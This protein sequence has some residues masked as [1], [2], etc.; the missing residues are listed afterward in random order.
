MEERIKLIGQPVSLMEAT[1]KVSGRYKY[2]DDM[3]AELYVKILRSPHPHSRIESIDT[4]RAEELEG[5]EAVLTHKDVPKRLMPRG[6][7]RACYVLEDHVRFVGDEVAAVAAKSKAVAEEALELIK[8]E[9]KVLPAVFDP[10]EAVKEDA[11]RIYPEGNVCGPQLEPLVEKGINTPAVYEWGDVEKGFREADV[12]IEDKFEVRPQVHTPIETHVCIASWEGGELTILIATQ[13]PY[14]VRDS[15]AYVLEMPE[16]RVRVLSPAIGGGFGSKEVE[17]YV[18]ITALLSSKAGGKSTKIVFTREEE[19]CHAKRGECK[20]HVKVGARKDGTITAILFKAYF[21]L[22]GYG[23]PTGGSCNFW[24]ESPALSYKAE[25]ARFEGWDVHTNHFTSQ[26]YRSVQLVD[27]VFA[28]EQAIDE[29]AEE[30]GM[31]PAEFRLKNMP[32]SGDTMPPKPH[33]TTLAP[34]PQR[35]KLDVYPSKKLMRNVM[36]KA[37]FGRWRGWGKPIAT[38]GPKR[39]GI[40]M[41]YA[42]GYSGFVWDGFMSMSLVLNKDGSANILS[43][44]QDLGTGVNTTL[45]MLAAESLGISM[46]DV[47]IF[48]GDTSIGQYDYFGARS[49][50][51]L[52]LGGHLLLCAI[53]DAKQKIRNMAAPILKVSPEKI[54]VREKKCYVRGKKEE[55][56]GLPQVLTMSITGSATGPPGRFFPEIQPGVKACQPLMQIAE[57][58]VDIETGQVKPL[59]IVTGNSPGRMINPMIVRGQYTGG[60][61]QS[62]GLALYEEF[63]YDGENSVYL[64]CNLADYRVPRALDTPNVE[65]VVLEEFTERPP[66]IGPPYGAMGVGEMG[67]PATPAAFANAIYNAIGIRV[68]KAPMTAEVVLEALNRKE[69][70]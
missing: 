60:A 64:S 57:V 4:S 30:L 41:A 25:N 32:E 48:T 17:R 21:D 61:I 28:L 14:E 39:R 50:R 58:E 15:L 6:S 38:D 55:A 54:E 42:F 59:R 10:E 53:E 24:G 13:T 12:V 37:R 44:A 47:A 18:P 2:V 22:G 51:S 52:T 56:V 46:E 69:K 66:H 11:P 35:A 65:N 34:A 26:N 27:T 29:V 31:S 19:Q 23:N 62:L 5:V 45:R 7:A 36:E 43:G 70:K 33:R 16:A 63:N 67:Y 3:P 1:E 9:Y 68:K 8:V 20:A 40:G 49:S